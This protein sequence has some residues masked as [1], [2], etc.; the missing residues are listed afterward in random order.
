MYFGLP[1]AGSG[2]LWLE[3]RLAGTGAD[4]K[5]KWFFPGFLNS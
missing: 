3:R 2:A 1:V 5:K 4:C